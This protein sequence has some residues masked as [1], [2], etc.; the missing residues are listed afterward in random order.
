[1]VFRSFGTG[2]VAQVGLI[3]LSCLTV[4]SLITATHYYATTVLVLIVLAAQVALLLH[5]VQRTSRDLSRFLLAIEHSDFSQSFSVDQNVGRFA[6]LSEAFERVLQRFRE[7]RSATEEQANYLSALVQHV[8]IAVIAVDESGRIDLFNQ[9]ARKLFG[10]SA[11]RNLLDFTAFGASFP[12]DIMKL[13]AGQ[14]VLI[15]VM[16]RHEHLQLNVSATELRIRGR[17]L[18]IVTLLDIRRE[19]EVRESTAWQN[20]IR[21]LTHEMMNSITPISSLAVTARE[22]LRSVQDG[23]AGDGGIR[24]AQEAMDT[25]AQRGTGLLHF[26]ESYRRL[27]HLPKPEARTFSLEALFGRIRQL[28]AHDVEAKSILLHQRVDE[29]MAELTADPELLEHAIINLTKNAIDA[30]SDA[31]S[32][33]IWMYAQ[34]DDAGR[35]TVV[36]ADNG[37]GIDPEVRENIFVPFYTT[38]RRGTGIG[39]SV[40]QQI[41]HAHHGS[42]EVASAP[43]KGALF[44]LTF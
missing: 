24:D 18:K 35:P 40:V 10:V 8:P 41:M 44:R 26:V 7:A 38:K 21:V 43:G 33:E 25:I 42:V 31:P 19:L 5:Y 37:Q 36:V 30:V 29:N 11:F 12:A 32:P 28:M 9:A 17:R 3:L 22:L 2:V 15:K 1:M 20:L 23:C 34:T 4:A 27:T 6:K 16:R 14:P 39:L 13:K